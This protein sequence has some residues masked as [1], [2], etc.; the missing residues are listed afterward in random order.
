V[1]NAPNSRVLTAS[2]PAQGTAGTAQDQVVGE[3]PV[4]GEVTE[5]VIY[6]EA[7]LTANAS[8]FRTFRLLNKG[9]DGNGAVV[10]ASFATDTVTADDLAD[11]DEKGI[12]LSVVAGAVNVTE[13][14][15]LAMD[16]TVGGT[17]VAH[18]GYGVKVTV[19][20][21]VSS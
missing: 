18:S 5:V 7:N 15:I 14:D 4:T 3:S 6:P 8:N 1:L 10:V 20:K 9:L 17:G 21:V 19:S 13:G 16:E 11:F 2:V 12:P